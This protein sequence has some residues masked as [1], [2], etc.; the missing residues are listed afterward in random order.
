MPVPINRVNRPSIVRVETIRTNTAVVRALGSREAALGPAI[1]IAVNIEEGV[2]LLET[3]PRLMVLGEIHDL[4][5]VVTVVG[6]VGSTVVVVSLGEN[7]DVLS[8]AERVL[9]DGGR[10]EMDVRVVTWGLVG[11]RA[12][13]VPDAEVVDGLDLLG[14]RL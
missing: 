6:A 1:G 12:I 4:L 9:E 2:L 11:G 7:E 8:A 14:D 3:E 10:T 5:G 13:K